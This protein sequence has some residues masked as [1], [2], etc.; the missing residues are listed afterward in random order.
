M[1][2]KKFILNWKKAEKALAGVKLRLN[3]KKQ[4]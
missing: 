3:N 4:K 1:I 2:K